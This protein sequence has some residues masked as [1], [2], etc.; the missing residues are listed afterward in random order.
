MSA[1]D[2]GENGRSQVLGTKIRRCV[3]LGA[4]GRS[5]AAKMIAHPAEGS[6]A[7]PAGRRCRDPSPIAR[8]VRKGKGLAAGS[9]TG[10]G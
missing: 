10:A 5:Q 4:R 1:K 2:R 3:R 9:G 6:R 7:E 8:W